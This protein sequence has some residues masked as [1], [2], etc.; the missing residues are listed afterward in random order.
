MEEY[1]ITKE[2]FERKLKRAKE[3][4]IKR[5]ICARDGSGEPVVEDLFTLIRWLEKGELII[6]K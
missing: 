6:E 3:Y 2:R 1:K 4:L 5:G